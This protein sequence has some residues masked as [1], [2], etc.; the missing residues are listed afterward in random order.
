MEKGKK[1]KMN[2]KEPGHSSPKPSLS[3]WERIFRYVN[4]RQQW[5]HH[6]S[7][8]LSHHLHFPAG[9]KTERTSRNTG[10]GRDLVPRTAVTGLTSQPLVFSSLKNNNRC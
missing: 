10:P 8:M 1:I 9:M 5:R 2:L 4:I 6:F 3:H 7:S